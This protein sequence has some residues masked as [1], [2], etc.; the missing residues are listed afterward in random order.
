MGG[1]GGAGNNAR[2][3]KD[4]TIILGKPREIQSYLRR[5]GG[6]YARYHKDTILEAKTD[7]AGNL[8][9]SYARADSYEEETRRTVKTVYKLQAGVVNGE[10]FGINWDKVKS[11]SGQTYDL[12]EVAKKNGLTWDGAKKQWRR[13]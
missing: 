8:T 10:P 3:S 1:R 6:G 12:R 7:G 11:I 4:G 9:F 2:S 13:K 5:G